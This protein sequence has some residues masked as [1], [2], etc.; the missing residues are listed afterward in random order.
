MK[1]SHITLLI[2]SLFIVVA[3]LTNPKRE[4]HKEVIKTKVMAYMQS[5]AKEHLKN[6]DEQ[7]AGQAFAALLGGAL[8]DGLIENLLSID[9]YVLF[10]TTKITWEGKTRVIGVGAF[11]N[12]F[13]SGKLDDVLNEGLLNNTQ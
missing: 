8:A 10:S 9:N 6:N 1:S 12:V 4:R 13:L 3:V 7:Q 2:I 5:T 11:G